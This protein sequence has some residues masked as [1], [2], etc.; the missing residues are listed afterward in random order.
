MI[1]ITFPDHSVREFPEGI[2]GLE[3]AQSI[4]EG[5]A[6]KVLSISVNGEVKDL[7]RPI[8]ND[9]RVKL[10]TWDDEE[11]K[12]TMWHSSAHIMASAIESLYPGTKFGIG[13]D[14]EN[15]FYY[16]IDLG[17]QVLS[18]ND[19]EKIEK[20][21]LE[22]AREKQPFV[23]REVPKQEALDFYSKKGDEYKVDLISDLEDGTI[24]FYESGD[25]TD[26]CRGPHLHDTSAIKTVKLLAL[27]AANWRGQEIRKQLTRVYGITFPK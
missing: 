17:D 25:F 1:K 7:T 24:S 22:I 16:D 19:F 21:M 2:T 3:I 23:R 4:S 15:G 14:I 13:P 10:Y 20:R 26:L 27:A 5:L 11:G 9:A 18:S 12:A 8:M 6:R